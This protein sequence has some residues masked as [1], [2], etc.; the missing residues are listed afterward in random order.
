MSDITDDQVR[1]L[2]DTLT[3]LEGAGQVL[4]HILANVPAPAPTLAE[5]LRELFAPYGTAD[6]ERII[7][8]ADQIEQERDADHAENERVHTSL[9]TVTAERDAARDEVGRL[10]NDLAEARASLLRTTDA[11]RAEVSAWQKNHQALTD[12][13]AVVCEERDHLAAE[14][15]KAN[16]DILHL[17]AERDA[18]EAAQHLTDGSAWG[19]PV[20]EPSVQCSDTTVTNPA[21]VPAGQ[22]WL[23]QDNDGTTQD[24]GSTFVAIAYDE[25]GTPNRWRSW[26]AIDQPV[27]L[28]DSDIKLF[29]HLVP[30]VDMTHVL[31]D[32]AKDIARTFADTLGIVPAPHTVT[33]VEELDALPFRSVILSADDKNP[34]VYQRDSYDE[35][36]DITAQG[37]SSSQVIRM[38]RSVNV[39]YQPKE[40]QK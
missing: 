13:H 7:T 20:T 26:D 29:A 8:R 30:E 19:G 24:T 15:D 23:V 1:D 36:L 22:P 35:W 37:Y 28:D 4:R 6:Q 16:T 17:T 27:K 40:D 12:H 21:D 10:T 11:H 9:R 25:P 34:D 14:I 39:L 18:L 31:T 33:S 32:A 5:E 38:E 3:R 2:R